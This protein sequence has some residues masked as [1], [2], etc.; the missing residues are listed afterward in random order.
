MFLFFKK[1]KKVI[2]NAC[3]SLVYNI[4]QNIGAKKIEKWLFENIINPNNFSFHFISKVWEFFIQ[5]ATPSLR[6]RH[7]EAILKIFFSTELEIPINS[8]QK[9][10]IKLLIIFLPYLNDPQKVIF[11]LFFIFFF[12]FFIYFNFLFIF[13]YFYLFLFIFIYFFE[14]FLKLLFIL[15]FLFL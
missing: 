15:I 1:K 13:I 5:H 7:L 2:L 8:I 9:R 11:Y 12:N 14:I 10:L 6:D 4:Y 3:C